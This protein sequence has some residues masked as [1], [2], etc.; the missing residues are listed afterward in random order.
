MIYRIPMLWLATILLAQV[1]IGDGGLERPLQIRL[2]GYLGAPARSVRA[3][4]EVEVQ[5]LDGPMRKLAVTKIVVLNGSMLGSDVLDQVAP[6]KPNFRITGDPVLMKQISD[7]TPAQL[8][9]IT[10]NL[11]LGDHYLLVSRV[12]GGQSPAASPTP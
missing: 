10:G 7:A 11:G 4:R 9:K 5:I 8:L 2:E 12:E 6:T 3:I 1:G